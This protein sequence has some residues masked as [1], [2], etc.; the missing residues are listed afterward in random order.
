MNPGCSPRR[1]CRRPSG[2]RGSTAGHRRSLLDWRRWELTSGGSS[3]VG[4]SGKRWR[5]TGWRGKE[6]G[7]ISTTTLPAGAVGWVGGGA[8]APTHGRLTN[9]LLPGLI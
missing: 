6:Q 5:S 4:A 2:A 8:R 1:A 3:A 9:F 7:E